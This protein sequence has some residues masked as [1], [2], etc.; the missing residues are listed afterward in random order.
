MRKVFSFL[1]GVLLVTS[2]GLNAG[3]DLGTGTFYLAPQ[4]GGYVF[5]GN[6]D[7]E[8]SPTIGLGLGYALDNHWAAELTFNYIDAEFE[9]GGGDVDGYLMRLDALYHFA[10]DGRL[11]PY[12]AAGIGGFKL[13]P[14]VGS[15]D[16]GFLVNA[17]GG[18]KY[19]LTESI[20]LRG[21]ARYVL[22]FDETHNNLIYTLSLDFLF[23]G[24]KKVTA[25]AAPVDSDGDGVSDARDQCPNT[26]VGAAVDAGG[27]PL[28]SDGD[29]IFDYLDQCPDTPAGVVV[30]A[31]GCPLDSDG[32]GV[33][34]YQDKCPDTPTG[35]AVDPKGCPLDSDGDGVSDYQ[36]KCPDTPRG[37]KVD[38]DGCPI[39]QQEHVSINID[40]QFETNQAEVRPQFHQHL[41]EVADFLKTYTNTSVVIEGHT[42]NTGDAAYNKDLSQRRADSVR[43]Y[44]IR[45]FGIDADR[46]TA[47]GYG[48]E[49]PVASNDTPQGRAQNRR[50]VAV[51]TAAKQRYEKK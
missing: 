50:V 4:I 12:L 25:A 33:Y 16:S 40:I 24:A 14:D 44:L 28:D 45:N 37:L 48:E 39:L 51:V 19:F 47:E 38:A 10:P 42:D 22:T 29:G 3:A 26:P 6:Q 11:V 34:D 17:G 32:D 20:A 36:D 31:G 5:E 18:V 30:D 46:L 15:S 49:R 41:K 35:V 7:L 13:D 27:C 8:H 1:F 23:G 21:D 9:S 2:F 43:D